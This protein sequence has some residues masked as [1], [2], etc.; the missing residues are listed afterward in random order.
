MKGLI[1]SRGMSRFVY[2]LYAY[3]DNYNLYEK[4]HYK[5]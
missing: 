5:A 4:N 2:N 3:F 1:V